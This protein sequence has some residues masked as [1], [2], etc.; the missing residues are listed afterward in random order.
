MQKNN[1]MNDIAPY[2]SLGAQ[3]CGSVAVAGGIGWWLDNTLGTSPWLLV[4]LLI[5]GIIAGM[6]VFIRTALKAD[7]R[8][9]K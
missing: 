1:I 7:N 8:K 2:V 6:T 5:F 4:T 9:T 3:L